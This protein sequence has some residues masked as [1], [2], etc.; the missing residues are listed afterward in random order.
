MV[1][2]K[3]PICGCNLIHVRIFNEKIF[4][5][6]NNPYTSWVCR[7]EKCKGWYCNDCDEWH[8]YNTTCLV[9]LIRCIRYGLRTV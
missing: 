6:N 1:K 4:G 2:V 5:T 9:S 8:P 3:C 7:N